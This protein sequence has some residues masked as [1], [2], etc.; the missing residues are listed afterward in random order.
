MGP[1]QVLDMRSDLADRLEEPL[2]REGLGK[3][4]HAEA[5]ALL[6]GNREWEDLSAREME[7]I[8]EQSE[9]VANSFIERLATA[10]RLSEAYRVV[11]DMVALLKHAAV[12]LE[13]EDRFDHSL[14]PTP[15]GMVHF[16]EPLLIGEDTESG[17]RLLADW[18]IWGPGMSLN[19]GG[20][21]TAAFWMIDMDRQK[22]NDF[23]RF[24]AEKDYFGKIRRVLGR[25]YL[26]AWDGFVDGTSLGPQQITGL[27]ESPGEGGGVG[28]SVA[29]ATQ[30]KTGDVGEPVQEND[31]RLL[32]ALWLL[33]DQTIVKLHEEDLE[34]PSKRRA[35]RKGLPPRVTTLA[36]RRAEHRPAEGET[37][38]EWHHRWIVRGHWRW[39]AC[40]AGRA[41]RKRIW[42][43]PHVKGPEDAPLKQSE[44]VY[45]LQR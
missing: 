29:L 6:S 12:S 36:L 4:I 45:S 24:L 32:Y 40:G 38:V 18:L 11:P 30:A 17:T 10:V 42:I 25:W 5:A 20:V 13:D 15:G 43:D 2:F 31:G 27:W 16:D 8:T 34:R 33:L 9:Q 28:A 39:Q 21:R 44:K 1:S 14:A 35:L 37:D 19:D 7:A 23:L 26:I 3:M 22:D 41:E